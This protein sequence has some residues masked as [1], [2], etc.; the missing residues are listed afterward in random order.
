MSTRAAP[1]CFVTAATASFVPGAI[2]A[3]ASFRRHH[4]EFDGDVVVVHDDLSQRHRNALQSASGAIRYQRV[5]DALRQRLDAL[6]AAQ[7]RLAHRLG[8]F[9]C[10][11][12][13]RLRGYRKV[14]WC[15]ADV[16]FRA[17]VN[18][19]FQ[20]AAQLLCRGDEEHL[21]GYCRNADTFA[22]THCAKGAL[23]R[24][25]GSGLLMID[26]RL[27][28]D[29]RHYE[30]L[31]EQ[32]SPETWAGGA[33]HTDQFV[34]NRHFAGRQT[35]VDWRYDYVVPMAGEIRARAGWGIEDAKAL[36]FAGP[37]KPWMADA[38]LRWTEGNAAFKP[39]PAYRWWMDAYIA[40][41]TK[42][43]VDAAGRRLR[44]G[45]HAKNGTAPEDR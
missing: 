4:P 38:M 7:P 21:R 8:E 42:A 20:S 25:F 24:T 30:A 10:L 26:G 23:R 15:D 5:S 18:D 1:V 36:H 29:G 27:I 43:H 32:V 3:I 19:L 22:P 11:E 45:Q 2:V 17:S 35:L 41:L 37:A 44:E 39:H 16:L 40:C 9:H 13:F 12:A 31:L 33:R 14:L 28:A 6:G 34:L